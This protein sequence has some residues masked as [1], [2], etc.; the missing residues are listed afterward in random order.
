MTSGFHRSV[1]AAS[2]HFAGWVLL[3]AAAGWLWP[4]GFSWVK[5]RIPWLLGLIMFGMGMTLTGAD[6]ARM[7]RRPRDVLAGM[8]C[9]FT[10]MPALAFLLS[11][12]FGL[13]P[14]LAAG[15]ILVG[16]CPGG[17]ASNVITYLARGDVALSV[18]LTAGS[19]LL[20]PLLT[21]W[22]TY[23]L[24]RRWVDIEPARLL[25]D[26]A[27]MVIVPVAL[28]V[29]VHALGGRRVERA[30][31][32]L[33][34]VSVAAIALIVAYIIG[35]SAGRIAQAAWPVFL[36]VALHNLLGLTLGYAS[37][38]ALGLELPQRKALTIEVGMQNSGLA[39][40]LAVAHFEPVAAVPGALFSVWHNLSGSVLAS[41]WARRSAPL[42]GPPPAAQN[43][44]HVEHQSPT[45]G[46]LHE[47]HQDP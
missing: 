40:A 30:A 27:R 37:G 16:A 10:I 46:T 18:S 25:W 2:R 26:I 19:T 14:E 35:A 17:T 23:W 38:R 1:E 31:R 6:F 36:V 44:L 28:G 21:P 3:G 4:E 8:A 5:P 39:V 42:T 43:G 7:G 33:P 13:P 12:A 20:A 45:K 32:C 22:L 34:L 11:A 24:A 15:V 29:V 9:Q 41:W 47:N